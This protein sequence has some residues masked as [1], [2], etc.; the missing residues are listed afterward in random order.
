MASPGTSSP[1]FFADRSAINCQTLTDR[2]ESRLLGVYRQP[3]WSFSDLETL[4]A[5]RI[6]LI[7]SL[8][9]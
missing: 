3:P 1:S 8:S 2:S 5:A 4:C 7:A 9:A 6:N